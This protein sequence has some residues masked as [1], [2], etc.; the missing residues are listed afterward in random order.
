MLAAH[1]PVGAGGGSPLMLVPIPKWGLASSLRGACPYFGIG[2]AAS[3]TPLQVS[4]HFWPLFD[5]CRGYLVSS[6]FPEKR[7][8]LVCDSCPFSGRYWCA[9]S[10]SQGQP[11]RLC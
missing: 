11:R 3:S 9:N 10:A 7:S 2:C 8:Q 5:S 6:A 1:S 4:R